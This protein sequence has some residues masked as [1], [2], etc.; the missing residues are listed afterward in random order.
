VILDRSY[1]FVQNSATYLATIK[2][3]PTFLDARHE[4]AG[5]NVIV[6]DRSTVITGSMLF[7]PDAGEMNA[8]NLLI[9]ESDSVAGSY[10][11]NWSVHKAHAE[12][13]VASSVLLKQEPVSAQPR[14]EKKK[15]GKKK[16]A[17]TKKKIP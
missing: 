6:I 13:F 17:V 5:S 10:I 14:S 9:I 16:G 2:S 1:P 3:I 4:V 15:T 8:D 11:N 7:T 12:E